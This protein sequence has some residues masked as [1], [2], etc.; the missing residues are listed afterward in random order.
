MGG[1]MK[2]STQLINVAGLTAVLLYAA[3][4]VLNIL[5]WNPLAAMP[6]MEL[7]EIYAEVEAASETTGFGVVAAFGVIGALL[8]LA[9]AVTFWTRRREATSAVVLAV[10]LTLL[11]L[12]GFGY[13]WASFPM[14]MGL[15]DT[16]AIGGGDKTGTGFVLMG[17]S[18]LAFI[19]L[20]PLLAQLVFRPPAMG[21]LPG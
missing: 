6:G 18:A 2:R 4:G 21:S 3:L 10:Y 11:C 14:G 7:H 5:V 12:G 17:V 16:F 20:V 8:G 19:A 1:T 13:F 9:A 15:A